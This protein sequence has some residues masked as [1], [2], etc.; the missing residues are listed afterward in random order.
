MREK[1][2][3]LQNK[4]AIDQ[5]K[6]QHAVKR[7]QEVIGPRREMIAAM[8]ASSPT[9]HANER[10]LVEVLNRDWDQALLFKWPALVKAKADAIATKAQELQGPNDNMERV[11]KGYQAKF[12]FEIPVSVN[13][14][15]PA[16]AENE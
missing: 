10:D 12:G 7:M 1:T 13:L 2:T 5:A 9:L 4:R 11:L 14:N 15:K 8:G 3:E 16:L 6:R